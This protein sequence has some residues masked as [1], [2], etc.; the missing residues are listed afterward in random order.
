MADLAA[1]RRAN[2]SDSTRRISPR[3]ARS[4]VASVESP[5]PGL[6]LVAASI[7]CSDDLA[8]PLLGRCTYSSV[9]PEHIIDAG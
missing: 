3:H 7:S 5:G 8:W 2:L 4:R 1:A 9:A 6:G